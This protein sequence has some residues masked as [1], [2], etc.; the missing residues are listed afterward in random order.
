MGQL[1]TEFLDNNFTFMRWRYTSHFI[2]N[3]S[4]TSFWINNCCST[5][6]TDEFFCHIFY[7]F[8]IPI[9]FLTWT[10]NIKGVFTTILDAP[11]TLSLTMLFLFSLSQGNFQHST[12][13]VS[14]AFYYPLSIF[15][16]KKSCLSSVILYPTSYKTSNDIRGAVFIFGIMWILLAYLINPGI[17]SFAICDDSSVIL[18]VSLAVI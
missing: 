5:A 1:I 16:I 12:F 13:L 4:I 10:F 8:S 15:W 18:Y 11:T 9:V 14:G 2:I 6:P 3:V 7:I 17:W